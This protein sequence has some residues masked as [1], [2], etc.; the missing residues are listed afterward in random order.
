MGFFIFIIIILLVIIILSASSN[1]SEVWDLS[2]KDDYGNK[3]KKDY[4]SGLKTIELDVPNP[5][6]VEPKVFL[7][8]IRDTPSEY[9]WQVESNL[10]YSGGIKNIVLLKAI[11]E[12]SKNNTFNYNYYLKVLE[13]TEKNNNTP[14]DFNVDK[15]YNYVYSFK[16][17]GS[18]I[19]IRKEY[20]IF[21]IE[22]GTEVELKRDIYNKFDS[23]AI[24]VTYKNNLLG[25]VPKES[26]PEVSEIIKNKFIAKI[27]DIIYKND[28]IDVIIYLYIS[29][30]KNENP[31]YFLDNEKILE[32]RDR[33][34]NS[35]YLKP[36]KD[37]ED[38]NMFYKKKVVITGIFDYFVDR[39]DLAKILYESGADIDV[40][41]TEKI[42]YLISGK[43]SGWKKLE[44]AKEF[45]IMIFNEDEI[46]KILGIKK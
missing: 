28:Y 22:E 31:L 41:V 36:K 34:I 40:G 15:L 8:F 23:N 33:K 44:K 32:L 26:I 43:D 4:K 45:G 38:V 13:K 5:N 14:D 10:S 46:L 12:K 24:S 27:S 2:E 16:I 7:D 37:A 9:L 29:E 42:D 39:N 19:S 25:Y 20:I 1:K 21:D 3:V 18:F 17:A 30:E 11:K 35:S 6:I